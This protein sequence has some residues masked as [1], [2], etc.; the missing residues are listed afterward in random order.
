M[1]IQRQE[2][3]V[4]LDIPLLFEAGYDTFV[5]LVIVLYVSPEVQLQRLQARDQIDELY[6][7]EKIKSQMPLAEKCNRADFVI[8]NNGTISQTKEQ[9]LKII[10]DIQERR[11]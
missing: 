5:D 6:A 1:A 4:F 7:I 10:N 11:M 2:G 9:L 3:I 8:D